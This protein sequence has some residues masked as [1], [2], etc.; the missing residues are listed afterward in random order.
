[1]R[2][3]CSDLF[4]DATD[5]MWFSP[6]LSIHTA[7]LLSRFI[8]P[9]PALQPG[10]GRRS[11]HPLPMRLIKKLSL[12]GSLVALATAANAADKPVPGWA[13]SALNVET[14]LLWEVG[15][16]TPF[17]Y[18]LMP[19]QLSWR[20]G[21]FIGHEF[22]DGSRIVVR[23]RLTMFAERVSNGPESHYIG[24]SASPSVEL[25][26]K[27]GKWSLFGGAGGGFGLVDSKGVPGG[28]GQDF[29]L[30]W[31]LRGGIEH[32]MQGNGRLTAGIMFQHMS[33]GGMTDPNPGINAFGFMLGYGWNY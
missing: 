3:G 16:N 5:G 26:D 10:T 28:Q 21:Q 11:I 23:H 12:V 20:S 22:A 18:R 4:C 7:L 17:D 19:V 15:N 2:A 30:N 13:T 31:F 33:N 8:P 14:G 32:V 29:T 25:W 6:S 24:V 1:M 9:R 27:T